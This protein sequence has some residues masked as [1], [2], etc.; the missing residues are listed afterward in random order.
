MRRKTKT[1]GVLLVQT[2]AVLLLGSCTKSTDLDMEISGESGAIRFAGPAVTRAAIDNTDGLNTNGKM[3]S[4]W[5]NYTDGASS[6]NV[7]NGTTVTYGNGAWSYD[8][9]RYWHLGNNYNFTAWYPDVSTIS[10]ASSSVN[11]SSDGISEIQGFD[12]T[13]GHDLMTASRSVP[14]TAGTDPGPVNFAF[15]H[16]LARVEIVGKAHSSLQDVTGVN[17][18]VVSAKFYGMSKKGRLIAD[19]NLTT[20]EDIEKAWIVSTTD[21]STE[22]SPFAAAG[23]AVS[24]ETA[25]V[26]LTDDG[27]TVIDALLFPQEVAATGYV[28]EITYATTQGDGV[29]TTTK[30]LDLGTLAGIVPKWEAGKHYRYTFTVTDGDRIAFDKPTVGTWS[31]A[32]GGII[33]VD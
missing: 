13:K 23:K 17:P 5:G 9:T 26:T 14:T 1:I 10:Q 15:R 22:A 3:F 4:V 16:L 24:E 21:Q 28:L 7:F 30:T 20:A 31:S 11:S 29:A 19:G 6:T 12:A 32:T 2:A 8:G 33:I 25:A 18:R 27:E